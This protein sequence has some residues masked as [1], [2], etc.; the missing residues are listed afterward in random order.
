MSH[1]TLAPQS[2]GGGVGYGGIS[3]AHW[4]AEIICRSSMGRGNSVTCFYELKGYT[5]ERKSCKNVSLSLL[6]YR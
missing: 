4:P 5:V 6:R 3:D 1:C 2:C